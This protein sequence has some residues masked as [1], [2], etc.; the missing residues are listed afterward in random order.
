MQ[1]TLIFLQTEIHGYH[2]SLINELHKNYGFHVIIFYWDKDKK[3]PFIPPEIE[4]VEF[5][6]KSNF[7]ANEIINFI[8]TK[9][10]K[11]IRVA[12]WMDKDYV[13]ISRSFRHNSD[14]VSVVCSDTRWKSNI[15]QTIGAI[16]FGKLI[17]KSFD[18]IM[19]PGPYQY[20][21]A[22]KL[23]FQKQRILFNNLSANSSSF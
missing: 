9:N 6:K 14:I 13:K 2:I 23:G 18:Y 15:K 20:E 11:L 16:L 10:V 7:S 19:V 1:E 3:T 8:K 17:N 21:Y 4:G 22:R 12:G 5:K